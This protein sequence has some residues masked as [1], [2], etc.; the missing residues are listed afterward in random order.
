MLLF[1][2]LAP[3]VVLYAVGYRVDVTNWSV[4]RT[5]IFVVAS[6]PRGARVSINGELAGYTPMRIEHLRPDTYTVAVDRDGYG[7]WQKQLT[8]RA[9]EA[10]IVDDIVLFPNTLSVTSLDHTIP[11]ETFV[12]PSRQ[13]M[14][15]VDTVDLHTTT[16]ATWYLND[17]VTD[18][19]TFT[20][21]VIDV[22]WNQSERDIAIVTQSGESSYR[23]WLW[24][25]GSDVT[26]LN[27]ANV[28][29]HDPPR[30]TWVQDQP[31]V[32]AVQYETAVTF[33]NA[34][35]ETNRA[36]V[37]LDRGDSLL[38]VRSHDVYVIDVNGAV[39]RVQSS[40]N[41]VIRTTVQRTGPGTYGTSASLS[42]ELAIVK[43]S[44]PDALIAIDASTETARFTVHETFTGFSGRLQ[45]EQW[46][47]WSSYEL[48]AI[49]GAG[50]RTLITR[51]S[52]PIR[53]ASWLPNHK[54]VVYLSGGTLTAIEFD[55]R[56]R[57]N[58]MD[59]V[60]GI[61]GLLTSGDDTKPWTVVR[62]GALAEMTIVP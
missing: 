44:S 43:R 21:E 22:Q 35:G 9:S 46:I 24:S 56:D 6:T 32:L 49:R 10:V 53:A 61:D 38:H 60:N 47:A 54:Y 14:L 15:V 59:L 27:V 7:R 40:L 19:S 48:T 28:M 31:F 34:G 20:G 58:Q 62:D 11:S 3:A 8:I 30:L 2:V 13:S 5:G 57:R 1:L 25:R 50:E 45:D 17:A 18:S 52:E 42:S 41:P 55:S 16:S 33:H 4:Y 37:P 23:L 51:I 26:P 29:F 36:S 39:V 12:S